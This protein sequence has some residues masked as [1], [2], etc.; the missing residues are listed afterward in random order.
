MQS[1]QDVVDAVYRVSTDA[2]DVVT[3]SVI[4]ADALGKHSRSLMAV[5]RGSKTGEQAVAEIDSAQ[6]A[7]RDGAA[8]LQG[9]ISVSELFIA[10]VTK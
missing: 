6:R 2:Q 9:L 10:D 7:V 1:I 4:C 3:R 5:V 8:R